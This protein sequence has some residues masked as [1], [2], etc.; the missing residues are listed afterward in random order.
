MAG[1]QIFDATGALMLDTDTIVVSA[2]GVFTIG[3]PGSAQSGSFTDA[4]LLS[5]DPLHQ[6]QYVQMEEVIF[7]GYIPTVTFSGTTVNWS[8]PK[9]YGGGFPVSKIMYG[10]C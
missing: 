10:V 8:F 4:R 2:L 5:G 9:T 6:V 3:G 1:L 7:I